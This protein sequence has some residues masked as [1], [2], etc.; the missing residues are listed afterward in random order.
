[1]KTETPIIIRIP[2]DFIKSEKKY[3]YD[4]WKKEFSINLF[5][6]QIEKNLYKKYNEF[7]RYKN[8]D[9]TVSNASQEYYNTNSTTLFEKFLFKKQISNK[10]NIK[11]LNIL[12]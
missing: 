6:S 12:L 8:S 2:S 3:E 4:Y 5:I 1:M 10:I 9:N 11:K 7:L